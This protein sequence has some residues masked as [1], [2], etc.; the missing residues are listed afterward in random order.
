MWYITVGSASLTGSGCFI[1]ESKSSN[2]TIDGCR[3]LA[4]STATVKRRKIVSGFLPV[5]KRS[6]IGINEGLKEDIFIL[7]NPL[8]YDK[9]YRSCLKSHVFLN[10]KYVYEKHEAEIRQKLRKIQET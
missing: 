3:H 8:N 9:T 4:S 10:K 5:N 1:S 7:K 6:R 2:T